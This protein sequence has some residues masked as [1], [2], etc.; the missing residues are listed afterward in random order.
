MYSSVP[1]DTTNS[2]TQFIVYVFHADFGRAANPAR[3]DLVL[4]SPPQAI[5]LKLKLKC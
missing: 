1:I 3:Y 2:G 4:D 5:F